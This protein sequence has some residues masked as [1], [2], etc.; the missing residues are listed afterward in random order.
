MATRIRRSSS[1]STTSTNGFDLPSRM[2]RRLSNTR[3][4]TSTTSGTTWSRILTA[5]GVTLQ[6]AYEAG[7]TITTDSTEGDVTI[8]GT[9]DLIVTTSDLLVDTTASISL[10]ADASSNFTVAAST[11][12][13]LD[14][15]L[16]S[17]NAGAGTG[18]VLVSSDD[19]I[20]LNAGGLL[21]IN[22][23]ANMDVD[24][25]G[26]Y[27]MLASG[28]FSIA[29][30]GASNVTADSGDLVLSTTTSGELDLTSADLMDVNAGAN[31][32]IDVTGTFD[33]LSTG[34]FS[35][36]GTGASTVAT[37]SGDL[38][39]STTTSGDIFVTA[40]GEVEM[41][42]DCIG[43]HPNSG[44][45]DT[46]SFHSEMGRF[47]LWGTSATTGNGSYVG[48]N[49]QR[50]S[51]T[52]KE[53]GT[54]VVLSTSATVTD[55]IVA[56]TA[57]TGA[58]DA[59]VE[60]ASSALFSVGD[61]VTITGSAVHCNDDLYEVAS[62]PDGTNIR[63]RGP[64]GA[65]ARVTTFTGLDLAPGGAGG[66]IQKATV[67]VIQT[68]TDGLWEGGTG[69]DDTIAFLNF[70]GATTLQE[71]YE[72][73]NT[74]TTDSTEGDVTI[75][76]TEDLIITVSDLNVDTTATST[77]NADAA[78][79]FTVDTTGAAQDLIL[80]VAGATDSS[81]VLS[82]S[83]TGGDALQITAT[84]GGIDVNVVASDANALEVSD[85]TN[86]YI[87]V[88]STDVT[89][90]LNQ[91]TDIVGSGIGIRIVTD[92]ALVAGDLVTIATSGNV[93]LADA[94]TGTSED[95]FVMGVSTGTFAG[96][97]T[98]RIFTVPGS[99]VPM[100]FAAAPAAA[101]NGDTVFL[102]TTSGQATLTPP[103]SGIRVIYQVGYLQGGNGATT[104]PTVL[105]MPRL[106]ATVP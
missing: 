82:S 93:E 4:N 35:I 91:F 11:A 46:S 25:T 71:A 27:D 87:N 98:A 92:D 30:T 42:A 47:Q 81:L 52:A 31:L 77:L 62:I 74:I 70:Q 50:V 8:T 40:A 21:D 34:V 83:G 49:T 84:A 63:L 26:T 41:T 59:N 104:T 94:D 57:A 28:T 24:V 103:G 101:N 3:W 95:A 37:T 66:T 6:D 1:E 13:A 100:R 58:L 99:L 90:D 19:E 2:P 88:N 97:N 51:T 67:S 9:E 53:A 18:N 55:S 48:H 22:A 65:T 32:D 16:S 86:E 10:D 20:D 73:G 17:T 102:D 33:M 5:G 79:N 39:L 72:N 96:T 29:G 85:G 15:T 106:V 80:S 44:N 105:F 36:A 60:V 69:D 43:V 38:T 7:N 14:L 54:W 64:N 76:G 68:G 45:E 12:G 78:S 23:G 61:L 75:G 89:L 56:T